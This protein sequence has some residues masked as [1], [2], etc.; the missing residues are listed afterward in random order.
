MV[1]TFLYGIDAI[2]RI[3]KSFAF[4]TAAYF[5]T[6]IISI[7]GWFLLN[8]NKSIFK[9]CL[10]FIFI[11]AFS[12]FNTL[13]SFGSYLNEFHK[14]YF[15]IFGSIYFTVFAASLVFIWIKARNKK[16]NKIGTQIIFIV[17]SGLMFFTGNCILLIA[18]FEQFFFPE[19]FCISLLPIVFYYLKIL[20][21]MIYNEDIIKLKKLNSISNILFWFYL[22]VYDLACFT[23][24][25]SSV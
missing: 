5:I 6:F 19:I 23:M 3:N 11:P 7:I 9:N 21:I 2:F 4:H 15:L 8:G 16:N 20:I 24:A 17:I 14:R 12:L 10:G 13:C 1:Y 18:N 22:V 25:A